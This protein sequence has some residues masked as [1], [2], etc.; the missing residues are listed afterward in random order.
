MIRI[1]EGNNYFTFGQLIYDHPDSPQEAENLSV[2]DA[3]SA[4]SSVRDWVQKKFGA[5]G[6]NVYFESVRKDAATWFVDLQLTMGGY[7]KYYSVSVD[8]TSG[9]VTGYN[10]KFRPFTFPPSIPASRGAANI[11]VLAALIVS[12]I[13]VIIFISQGIVNLLGGI[14]DLY[15]NV[16]GGVGRMILGIFLLAFGVIDIYL[17][18]EINNIRDLVDRGNV[19][20]AKERNSLALGVVAIIFDGVVTGILLI[21]AREEINRLETQPAPV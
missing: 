21:V 6:E 16:L 5:S 11:L 19:N 7:R 20:A 1:R 12:I 4:E 15:T 3:E 17:T 14:F 10:E 2:N 13:V 9:A 18:V 8:S